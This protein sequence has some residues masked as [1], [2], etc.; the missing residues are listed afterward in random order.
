MK[1]ARILAIGAAVLVTASAFAQ[2]APAAATASK[3]MMDCSKRHD[4]GA[5]KGTPASKSDCA[6]GPGQAASAAAK[7]PAHDHGKV[8]KQQ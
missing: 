8:H 4:H 3:P 1:L 7:K 2:Q 6:N 5:E